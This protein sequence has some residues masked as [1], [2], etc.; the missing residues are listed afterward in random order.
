[1]WQ[2]IYFL[3]LLQIFLLKNSTI[4]VIIWRQDCYCALLLIDINVCKCSE[5]SVWHTRCL[6][7]SL[8]DQTDPCHQDSAL[9]QSQVIL[10]RI[11][12]QH[13]IH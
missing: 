7:T 8:I 12:L 10:T 13:S 5:K 2:I 1:M 3:L 11:D 4:M 9:F 6:F